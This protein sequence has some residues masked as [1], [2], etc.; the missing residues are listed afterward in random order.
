MFERTEIEG[1]AAVRLRDGDDDALEATFLPG[2]GMLG[3]SLR[4]GGEELLGQHRG[5]D[6]Y[7]REARTL[8]IP[9]LHPWANR[10][11]RDAYAAAGA[12]VELA[13]DAPGVH[14]DGNGL[15]IHGLLAGAPEWVVEPLDPTGFA[16]TFD[17]AARADLLP[18]FPFPHRLRI[19]VTLARRTLRLE[20]TVTATGE[21]SVPLA[22]GFHPY[23]RIPGL[24]RVDWEVELPALRH[25]A[26]DGRGIP[27]G[28][29][30][31]EPAA[32]FLLGTR[33]FDDAYDRVEPG[34]VFALQGGG[35]RIEVAFEQ[36]FPAAQVYAP[37]SEDV[38]C[39][40]PM[41]APVDALVSGDGLRLVGPG[42][43]DT[44]VFSIAVSRT[45]A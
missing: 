7:V 16:A 42:E 5:V 35:R 25:L 22:Y 15:A 1:F 41:T 10:L 17:F 11:S 30:H 4:D 3:L 9:L 28:A 33:T 13:P 23:L 43:S 27:T 12:T 19:E 37:A 34:A 31:A 8:G 29:A 44:S 18:S 38:V 21:R 32:A 40:E 26:L 24:P 36:G 2:A 20:T 45:L 14:R 6:A 39:F